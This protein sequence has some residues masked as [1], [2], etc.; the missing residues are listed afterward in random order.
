MVRRGRNQAK[1]TEGAVWGRKGASAGV[2]PR[3]RGFRGCP[4]ESTNGST[5]PRRQGVYPATGGHATVGSGRGW[6]TRPS[7]LLVRD[8]SCG[9]VG[10]AYQPRG[11]VLIVVWIPTPP[12][13]H[14]C[15]VSSPVGWFSGLQACT[16]TGDNGGGGTGAGGLETSRPP[17][18]SGAA[19]HPVHPETYTLLAASGAG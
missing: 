17:L 13:A 5:L 14:N 15:R 16:S 10:E 2:R 19:D 6:P 8:L 12:P 7:S 1:R 18:L 3:V 9:V 4:R 11:R